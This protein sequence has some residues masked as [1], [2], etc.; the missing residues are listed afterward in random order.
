MSF[1]SPSRLTRA[2][3]ASRCFSSAMALSA[4]NSCQKPTPALMNSIARMMTRSAQCRSTAES[5]A[6]TSIIQGIGP[7]KKWA[8]RSKALT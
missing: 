4:L 6:A 2:F 8:R 5:A 3:S 7:Q 1:H